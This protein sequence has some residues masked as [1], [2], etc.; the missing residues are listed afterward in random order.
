MEQQTFTVEQFRNYLLQCDSLGDALYYLNA[1]EILI[2]NEQ[3]EVEEE[4][5]FEHYT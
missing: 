1:E 3:Q 2:R 4:D 5:T